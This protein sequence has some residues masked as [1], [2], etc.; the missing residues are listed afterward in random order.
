[1]SLEKAPDDSSTK[2]NVVAFPRRAETST[3]VRAN[4]FDTDFLRGM[5]PSPA[6]DELQR[7]RGRRLVGEPPQGWGTTI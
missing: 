7:L 3:R 5:D 2:P 1:M 4:H 6:A